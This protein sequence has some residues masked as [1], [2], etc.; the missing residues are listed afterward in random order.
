M[1]KRRG[2]APKGQKDFKSK[3]ILHQISVLFLNLLTEENKREQGSSSS[4]K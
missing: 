1:R 4:E 2:G 3:V